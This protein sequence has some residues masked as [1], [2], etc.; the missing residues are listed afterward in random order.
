MNFINNFIYLS[1]H[2]RHESASFNVNVFELKPMF[3]NKSKS[4]VSL[5]QNVNKYSPI[6]QILDF[7]DC[8][9]NNF[10]TN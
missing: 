5:S 9:N 7:G 2:S 4:E 3:T 1:T 8:G 10:Y 6:V